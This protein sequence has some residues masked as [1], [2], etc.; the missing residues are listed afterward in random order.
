MRLRPTSV[1][2]PAIAGRRSGFT[3]IEILVAI[4]LTFILMASVVTVFGGV[5][6]GIAQSRRALEQFDRLRTASQQL[7]IDLQGATVSNVAGVEMRPEESQGYFE[8]VAGT[9]PQAVNTETSSNSPDS[10]AGPRGYFVEF[11]S[12]NPDRQF[13][14]LYQGAIIQSDVAEVV[15]FLRGK[16]L[17]RRVLLVT[18]GLATGLAGAAKATFYANNDISAHI[19]NG[20]I[21]PNSLADLTKRENRYAHPASTFPFDARAWG[22]LGL[23]TLAECS[24]PTWMAGWVN[25]S[26]PP[27]SGIPNVPQVDLWDSSTGSADSLSVAK[28]LPNGVLATDGTR[29][30][31]DVVLNNVIG[32]D[33]QVYG[34]GAA[35]YGMRHRTPVASAMKTRGFTTWTRTAIPSPFRPRITRRD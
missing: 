34:T 20:Q 27:P 18:P 12:R 13:T 4:T 25:G 11:T 1:F 15:W 3:L 21:V 33:I 14:G 26:T 29:P 8:V 16:T 19:S 24:S 30:A 6:E 28:L 5:G 31:N 17:H 35:A 22:C 32:F 10:T 9:Q 7:R 23:P 2:F